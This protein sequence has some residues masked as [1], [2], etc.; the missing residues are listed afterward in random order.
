MEYTENLGLAKPSRNADDIADVDV[1]SENFQKIDDDIPNNERK[2]NKVQRFFSNDTNENTYPSTKAVVDYAVPFTNVLREETEETKPNAVL[3]NANVIDEITSTHKNSFCNAL[4]GEKEGYQTVSIDDASPVESDVFITLKNKNL[5][6]I[7]STGD[8]TRSK[9]FTFNDTLPAGV[10]SFS[11]VVEST[12][13]DA[14]ACLFSFTLDSVSKKPVA[15]AR[16]TDGA[17]VKIE[18]I[19][20]PSSFNG[21]TFYASTSNVNATGDTASFTDIQIEKGEVATEYVEYVDFATQEVNVSF[22]KDNTT[23]TLI[24]TNGTATI[25]SSSYMNFET[26]EGVY[27]SISYNKDINRV[28]E[29]LYRFFM[30]LD[31]RV[32]AIEQNPPSGAI[33]TWFKAETNIQPSATIEEIEG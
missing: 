32:T 24:I 8:F 17:R 20:I 5:C 27:I 30:N 21:I 4:K 29:Y 3:Y 14:A 2:S 33:Q 11:A 9:Q 22:T 10:Y 25:E 19:S 6:S 23:E 31:E 13:T 26:D 28:I 7:G 18:N 16:S 1:I 12:D 15:I